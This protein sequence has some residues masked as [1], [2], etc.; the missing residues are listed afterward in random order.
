MLLENETNLINGSTVLA[1]QRTALPKEKVRIN[2]EVKKRQRQQQQKERV[3]KALKFAGCLGAAFTVSFT[4]I[5]RYSTIYSNQKDLSKVQSEIYN[6]SQNNESLKVGLL[7]FN[8]ISYI[9]EIATKELKMVKPIA[10]NAVH[11]D[12]KSVETA[13]DKNIGSTSME[14]LK[15]IKDFL[16]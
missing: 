8:N 15:K 2:E 4:I 6:L 16:F 9:E 7:K 3:Y 5:F 11:C 14:W 12:L 10:G 13:L 1:P